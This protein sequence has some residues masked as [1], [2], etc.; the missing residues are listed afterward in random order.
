MLTS[1]ADPSFITLEALAGKDSVKH[2]EITI[3]ENLRWSS[4][5]QLCKETII[6]HER[7][8][9]SGLYKKLSY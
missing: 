1:L 9:I 4:H 3:D 7:T 8:G 5:F 2:L 6:L